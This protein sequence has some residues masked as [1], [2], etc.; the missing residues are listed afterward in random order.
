MPF[1]FDFLSVLR[2]V[3]VLHGLN[4]EECGEYI[5][6]HGSATFKDIPRIRLIQ[7][8]VDEN[9]KTTTKPATLK[10]KRQRSKV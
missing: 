10:R 4:L 9:K 2:V 6:Q 1:I 3:R 5:K 8:F 7:K